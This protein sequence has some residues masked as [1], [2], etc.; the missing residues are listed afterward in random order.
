MLNPIIK[1]LAKPNDFAVARCIDTV[2]QLDKDLDEIGF[3]PSGKLE[4]LLKDLDLM[5]TTTHVTNTV[6]VPIQVVEEPDFEVEEDD[7]EDDEDDLAE[8]GDGEEE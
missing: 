5:F 4:S 1:V 7:Y 2:M 3:E 8:E 6:A